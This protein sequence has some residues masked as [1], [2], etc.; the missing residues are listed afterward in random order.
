M[1]IRVKRILRS[2][3]AF[4]AISASSPASADAIDGNWC[5]GDGRTFSIRGPEIVTP[6][7][8]RIEGNYDRHYFSYVVPNPEPGAGQTVNL[9]LLGEN[10]LRVEANAASG[11]PMEIWNRCGPSIS[12]LD[13]VPSVG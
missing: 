7:G 5:S 6:R 3:A 13:A 9:T 2:L 12:G 8:S 10:T 11:S 1:K 4:A